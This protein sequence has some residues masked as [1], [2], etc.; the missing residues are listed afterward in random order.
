M[1][2]F[3]KIMH[4]RARFKVKNVVCYPRQWGWAT[5]FETLYAVTNKNISGSCDE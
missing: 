2:F 5:S 3:D 1:C 4:F